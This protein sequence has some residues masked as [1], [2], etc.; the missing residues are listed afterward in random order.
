MRAL[1]FPPENKFKRE[2]NPKLSKAYIGTGLICYFIL[3]PFLGGLPSITSVLS[4]GWNLVIVGLILKCWDAWRRGNRTLFLR[5]LLMTV[6]LPFITVITQGF[7]G[8]GAVAMLAVLVFVA[9]FYRPRWKLVIAGLVLGFLGLSLYVTY[10]RD[11]ND[12]RATVWGGQSYES[13]FDQIYNTFSDFELFDPLNNAHL[14]RIDD[15]MNQSALIGA[16]IRYIDTGQ[17]DYAGGETLLNAGIAIIPRAIWWDK[18]I[19]AGSGNLVATYT[20]I[21]FAEGTSVGVGQVMEFYI[22]FGTTGVIIGFLVLGALVAF[23]DKAAA[24]RLAEGDWQS[25]SFW[26]LPGLG[27]MQVGGQL[28]EVTMSVAS[29]MVLAIIVKR[30]VLPRLRGKRLTPDAELRPSIS[31]A[32]R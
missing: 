30:H 26:F 3:M 11:R 23:F 32:R 8:Y 21:Q 18:P 17:Q 9:N 27:F 5:W 25:F 14:Q 4:S 22:N 24:V 12:I 20:G 28:V 19:T 6:C 7:L 16:S 29:A 2:P 31:L 10:M 15:R 13:R 1:H